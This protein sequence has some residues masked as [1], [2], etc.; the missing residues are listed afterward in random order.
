MKNDKRKSRKKR[1]PL[2]AILAMAIV[3]RAITY[4]IGE[5]LT[6]DTIL[7]YSPHNQV[8]AA[9]VLIL[10]F[11]MKSLTV[12]FPLSVLYLASGILFSPLPAIL[13]SS[14]GLAVT[15]TIPY[16]LGRYSGDNIVN[17]ICTKYPKA[18]QV[19]EYQQKNSFFACFITRIVGFLPGDIVS[20]YFGACNTSYPIYLT[21]G[22]CGSML[23][24]ITTTLLG[25][26]LSDPFSIE[27][28]IVLICRIMVS[29]GAVIINYK[30]QKQHN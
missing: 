20:L 26:K 5:D 12:I 25:D 3:F 28:I 27:F 1:I 17:D 6:V 14:I 11:G 18:A 29:A 15:I 9:G 24:I 13:V 7:K 23:S 30:L 16:W 22:L 2:I 8:L 10:F 21:A 4:Y 19:Q